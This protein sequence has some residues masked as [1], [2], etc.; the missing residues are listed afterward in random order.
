MTDDFDLEGLAKRAAEEGKEFG[1]LREFAAEIAHTVFRKLV[2]SGLLELD[3]KSP[4]QVSEDFRKAL[5]R[6]PEGSSFWEFAV[7]YTPTLLREARRYRDNGEPLL[8][9]LMYATW[10][11]HWANALITDWGPRKGIGE[12]ERI[13]IIRESNFPAKMGWLLR[14][15]GLPDLEP[16]HRHTA[17]EIVSHRNGFVHHKYKSHDPVAEARL[18]ALVAR[19]DS[20]VKYL[21]SYYIRNLLAGLE[22]I[23]EHVFKFEAQ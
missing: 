11:E 12:A 9:C 3:G 7:D 18:E 22:R 23:P 14:V 2:A 10:L 17:M 16:A 8:A 19:F 13:A 20:T 1:D 4:A 6:F 21:E 5:D 15:L